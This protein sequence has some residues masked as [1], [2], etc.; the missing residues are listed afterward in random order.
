M[1][2]ELLREAGYRNVRNM[3]GGFG[4]SGEVPGWV[5]CG[6]A[7]EEGAGGERRYES[8]SGKSR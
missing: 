6:Y 1:A 2:A 3:E 7:V 4:G 8:L 5:E